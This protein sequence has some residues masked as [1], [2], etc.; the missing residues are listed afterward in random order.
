MSS[1]RQVDIEWKAKGDQS[2]ADQ[3]G[4]VKFAPIQ[5]SRC[6]C[7]LRGTSSNINLSRE[8]KELWPRYL[9]FSLSFAIQL[10]PTMMG[11]SPQWYAIP[12]IEPFSNE[13]I[14]QP[15]TVDQYLYE[16]AIPNS[17]LLAQEYDVKN[18]DWAKA[19]TKI[20]QSIYN[21]TGVFVPSPVSYIAKEM[22]TLPPVLERLL[23][24]KALHHFNSDLVGDI[25]VYRRLRSENLVLRM[26]HCTHTQIDRSSV[27]RLG[28]GVFIHSKWQPSTPKLA[29]LDLPS[30]SLPEEYHDSG[31]WSSSLDIHILSYVFNS[32][33]FFRH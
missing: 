23:A 7:H 5:R 32:T 3:E 22:K 33:Q 1:M 29:S 8:Q 14:Y 16:S 15:N 6:I 4:W 28:N 20:R 25:T 18:Q 17:T 30:L 2:D 9:Y 27:T 26:L 31:N 13:D 12:P 10:F 11:A 24:D 21:T 19:L